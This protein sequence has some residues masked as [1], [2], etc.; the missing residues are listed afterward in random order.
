LR[1]GAKGTKPKKPYRKILVFWGDT[2]FPFIVEWEYE[3]IT[4]EKKER[5]PNIYTRSF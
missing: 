1:E 2:T 5:E 3:G 4:A